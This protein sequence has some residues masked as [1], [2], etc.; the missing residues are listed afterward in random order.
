M[1]AAA[2]ASLAQNTLSVS[3][4]SDQLVSTMP[5]YSAEQLNI[6]T[7][8]MSVKEMSGAGV[9]IPDKPR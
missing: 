2:T 9:V 4:L 8:L 5:S 1:L 3:V 7:M 6:G